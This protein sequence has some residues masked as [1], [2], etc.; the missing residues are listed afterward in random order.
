[1]TVENFVYLMLGISIGFFLAIPII[2]VWHKTDAEIR[3]DKHI[4][5]E[6]EDKMK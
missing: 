1:M 4:L 5:D 2:S 3:M 6:F